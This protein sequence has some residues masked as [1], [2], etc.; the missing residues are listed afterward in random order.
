MKML[1]W[2]FCPQ[3]ITSGKLPPV[4]E[5]ATSPTNHVLWLVI[6][7]FPLVVL[8]TRNKL[9]SNVCTWMSLDCDDDEWLSNLWSPPVSSGII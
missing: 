8:V 4:L 9:K 7:M 6:V 1:F 5:F 3:E 2:S